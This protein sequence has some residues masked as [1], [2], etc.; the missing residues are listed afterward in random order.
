MGWHRLGTMR[1]VYFLPGFR[2]AH[3]EVTSYV[4]WLSLGILRPTSARLILAGNS[5]EGFYPILAVRRSGPPTQANPTAQTTGT[6]L[7]AQTA[8]NCDLAAIAAH[9]RIAR[10]SS[11]LAG[12]ARYLQRKWAHHAVFVAIVGFSLAV[13]IAAPFDHRLS[14]RNASFSVSNFSRFSMRDR[15]RIQSTSRRLATI[16]C[17]WTHARSP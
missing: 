4:L 10:D 8:G 2:V 1:A 7:A 5:L 17:G 15:V 3:P 6:R 16:R 13:G 12:W 9:K 14:A 11:G